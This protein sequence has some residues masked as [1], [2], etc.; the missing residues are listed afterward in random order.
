MNFVPDNLP[1][2][3]FHWGASMPVW[4]PPFLAWPGYPCFVRGFI[5][6]ARGGLGVF[7]IPS[8]IFT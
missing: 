8:A 7:L 1:G 5:S 3:D 2:V 6:C 4:D